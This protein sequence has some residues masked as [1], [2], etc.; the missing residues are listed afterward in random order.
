MV[1]NNCAYYLHKDSYRWTKSTGNDDEDEDESPF[2][3]SLAPRKYKNLF[4]RLVK[5]YSPSIQETVAQ[6]LVESCQRLENW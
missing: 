6:F 4:Y 3:H 1:V 5:E 2:V